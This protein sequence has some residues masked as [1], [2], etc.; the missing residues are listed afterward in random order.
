M[1]SLSIKSQYR[2]RGSRVSRTDQLFRDLI[3]T[4]GSFAIAPL[5]SLRRMGISLTDEEEQAYVATWRHIG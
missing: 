4:L 3:A 2:Q 5:W 1:G